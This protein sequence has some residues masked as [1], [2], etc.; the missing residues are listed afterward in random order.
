MAPQLLLVSPA[1]AT[2][3]LAPAALMSVLSAAPI[4]ALLVRRGQ[5]SDA[6][7]AAL[8]TSLINIG[9]GAGCAV[10][11]ENDWALAKRLGADGVHVTGDEAAVRAAIK[12]LKPQLIVGA[13]PVST[14]HDAM[15]R[16]ELDVDYVW[17]G[18]LDNPPDAAAPELAQWW[19]QTFEI[20]AVLHDPAAAAAAA[21]PRG[22]EFFAIGD[23]IWSAPAPAQ[24]VAAIARALG[25]TP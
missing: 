2:P 25:A 20:P 23:S 17:F 21:D 7:Y 14:R 16:G 18:A 4:A 15:T 6:D 8:A 1:A 11:L 13:G 9:Q 19:A 10:L 5:R 12:A 3:E 24:A 22:A